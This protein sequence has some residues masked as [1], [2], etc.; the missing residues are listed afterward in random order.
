MKSTS[1]M[2]LILLISLPS[3]RTKNNSAEKSQAPGKEDMVNLNRYL[4]QKDREIIQNYV[5]RKGLEMTE[6]S[7]GF[8]FQIQSE[9][10]GDL[11]KE[12]D[13]ISM[14]YKCSLLDGTLCYSSETLGPKDVVVGKSEPEPGLNEG[15]KLLRRG[16]KAV[17]ILPPF[18]AYGFVGD[19]KKIPPRSIIV[20]EISVAEEK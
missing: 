17:F 10:S 4:V 16:A 18:M 20:Y 11:L 7:T 14:E 15:L 9:G 1:I 6:S 2:F 12:N 5:E 8:W 13:R 19:G 3:C